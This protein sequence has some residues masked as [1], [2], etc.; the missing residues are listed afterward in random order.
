M[1]EWMDIHINTIY[2]VDAK[3]L[4]SKQCRYEIEMMG[5]LPDDPVIR[6]KKRRHAG[7]PSEPAGARVA[8]NND[9]LVALEFFEISALY[10]NLI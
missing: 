9:E 2:L 8:R 7:E 3:D 10:C 5:K 6:E 4:G 1:I